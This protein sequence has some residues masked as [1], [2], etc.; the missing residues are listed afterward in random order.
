MANGV[1]TNW[2]A[3]A[4]TAGFNVV[5]AGDIT[6]LGDADIV[7]QNSGGMI[8]YADMENGVFNHWVT[9]GTTPGWKV[10]AVE[11]VKGNGY[12]DI[13]IQNS[14]TGQIDYADMTTGTLQGWVAVTAV[15]GYTAS[16][17]P[18]TVS[19][20][21]ADFVNALSS[22]SSSPGA[23]ASNWV[24]GAPGTT[25]PLTPSMIPTADTLQLGLHLGSN[26]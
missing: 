23:E 26:G 2:V 8:E 3:V 25:Q 13:V 11:D 19:G 12:D 1:V 10:A 16:T 5:G 7:V 24:G 18:A 9:V 22:V 4:D 17:R 6:R 20:G 15:P 14:S 21:T